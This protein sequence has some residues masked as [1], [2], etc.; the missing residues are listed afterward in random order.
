[1]Q[2]WSGDWVKNAKAVQ[3]LDQD[4]PSKGGPNGCYVCYDSKVWDIK[5][6]ELEGHGG[7]EKLC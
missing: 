4:R 3:R 7:V 5:T 2:Q 1:M 6:A